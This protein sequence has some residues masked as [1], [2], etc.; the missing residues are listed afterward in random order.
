MISRDDE[1]SS[2]NRS[3]KQGR[4][5]HFTCEQNRDFESHELIP[6]VSGSVDILWWTVR[7]KNYVVRVL[8]SFVLK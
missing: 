6:P 2:T 4:I 8:L 5:S 3:T 1:E 7:W